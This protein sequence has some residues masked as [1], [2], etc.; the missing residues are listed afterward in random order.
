MSPSVYGVVRSF[1]PSSNPY[2]AIYRNT[3]FASQNKK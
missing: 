2:L 1:W 3:T